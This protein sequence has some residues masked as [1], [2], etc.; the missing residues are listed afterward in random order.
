MHFVKPNSLVTKESLRVRCDQYLTPP[1]SL[2]A[3]K[4]KR[5]LP[6]DTGM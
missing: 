3:S 2:H 5:D 1:L 4:H 6:N